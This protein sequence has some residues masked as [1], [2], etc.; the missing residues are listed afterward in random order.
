MRETAAFSGLPL[1]E[2]LPERICGLW[3]VDMRNGQT[4]AFLRFEEQVQETFAVQVLPQIR[5]PVLRTN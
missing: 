5:F 3:V 4:V 1:T 2:R